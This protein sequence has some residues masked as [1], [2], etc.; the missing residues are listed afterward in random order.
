MAAGLYLPECRQDDRAGSGGIHEARSLRRALS[1]RSSL[2]PFWAIAQ[3]S[4][5][6]AARFKRPSQKALQIFVGRRLAKAAL[7]V[8]AA[9]GLGQPFFCRCCIIG[10]LCLVAG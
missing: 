6:L 5:S 8:S 1:A 2:K 3:N 10:D 7:H 4:S 9:F